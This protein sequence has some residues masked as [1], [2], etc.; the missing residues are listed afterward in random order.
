M[1]TATAQTGTAKG[2]TTTA[3]A[4]RRELE[5]RLTAA[6]QTLATC[7]A[8]ERAHRAVVENRRPRGTQPSV[9]EVVTARRALPEAEAASAAAL[10]EVLELREQVTGAR[11]EHEA[12]I[13]AR[14][15]PQ[16]RKLAPRILA[17]MTALEE[18]FAELIHLE[19]DE[20]RELQQPRPCEAGTSLVL[21]G[22]APSGLP[23]PSHR[24]TWERAA[25]REGLLA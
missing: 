4:T 19:D 24:E 20:A 22:W 11:R 17:A 18:A 12:E 10:Q 15:A 6:E 14:F 8:T 23:S 2:K 13:R 1:T 9:L 3:G 16:K 5:A 21:T 7:E 25:R